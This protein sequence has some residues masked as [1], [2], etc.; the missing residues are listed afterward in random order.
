MSIECFSRL[1]PG[2]VP[3]NPGFQSLTYKT[4]KLININSFGFGSRK[5]YSQF[6]F[7]DVVAF[8]TTFDADDEVGFSGVRFR[9][10]IWRQCRFWRH[11]RRRH[12]KQ[13]ISEVNCI[14]R[15]SNLIQ[16]GSGKLSM[17]KFGHRQT[18]QL[19]DS[20]NIHDRL[21]MSYDRPLTDAGHEKHT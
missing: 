6:S 17:K 3:L 11:R 18:G 9:C 7:I 1:K 12:A 8:Q 21:I 20:S 4:T 13:K 10:N 16:T 19:S 5:N 2:P 15:S 14:S